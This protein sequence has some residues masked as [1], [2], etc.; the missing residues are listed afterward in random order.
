MDKI[1]KVKKNILKNSKVSNRSHTKYKIFLFL[2]LLNYEMY[3][4]IFIISDKR[5]V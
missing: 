1:N 4:I 2:Q 3:F 5:I